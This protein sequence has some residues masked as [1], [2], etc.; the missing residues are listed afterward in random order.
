MEKLVQIGP[1]SDKP[2]EEWELN[3]TFGGSV[4]R[5]LLIMVW[6]VAHFLSFSQ[7]CSTIQIDSI[8]E[9]KSSCSEIFMTMLHDQTDRDYVYVAAKD[10]GLKVV[11]V[12]NPSSPAIV[13]SLPIDSFGSLHVTNLFQLNQVLYLALGNHFDVQHAGIA[14]IDIGD[15]SSPEVLDWDTVPGSSNGGGVVFVEGDYAYLGAM[16]SGLVI[17]DVSVPTEITR[18]SSFIPDLNYP[19]NNPNPDLYNVRGLEVRNSIAYV[20]YDAGGI[21]VVNCTDKMNPVETGR[22]VN[23]QMY[24]PFNLPRA[25]NNIVLDDTLAYIAVDYCGVEV[26]SIADTANISLVGWWN[27]YDCPGNNWFSSPVHANELYL[28]KDC[29]KLMVSTGKSDMYM[30]DVSDPSQ[31]DSCAIYGGVSNGLGTWG[32]SVFEE[33]IYLS[34]MCTLGIPFASSA[35]SMRILTYNWCNVGSIHE[36]IQQ[37]PS[38]YPNPCSGTFRISEQQQNFESSIAVYSMAG[39]KVSELSSTTGEFTV[40]L[41]PGMYIVYW[42]YESRLYK[43]KLIIQ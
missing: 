18:L 5:I 35:S 9:I 2:S 37:S 34:Y 30:L 1:N 15:P 32:I 22:F 16:K 8:S 21:R 31:P 4:K 43:Q 19:V 7:D 39:Y 14:V 23:E 20:C 3:R 10:G 38:I 41:D 36:T 11:D 12:R 29:D 13:A 28:D 26:I 24:K 33:Y 40:D 42:Y 17:F 6:M 27:P 25:Y